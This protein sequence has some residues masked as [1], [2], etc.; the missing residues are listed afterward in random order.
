MEIQELKAYLE[1]M[2]SIY[3]AAKG[4]KEQLDQ[5]IADKKNKKKKAEEDKDYYLEMLVLL[6]ES[7]DEARTQSVALMEEL[8]T[9][10][11]Q[12]VFGENTKFE[13]NMKPKGENSTADFSVITD[14]PIGIV[15]ADPRKDG[16]GSGD[17]CA[18]NILASLN[19]STGNDITAP[20][21]LDEPTKYV[22]DNHTLPAA[23]FIKDL[24]ESFDKQ[25]IMSTHDPDVAA[26]ADKVYYFKK[27]NG[28]TQITEMVDDFIVP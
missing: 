11:L 17:I 20:L 6:Q 14:E 2:K 9:L 22:D 7:S 26:I 28:V 5:L 12:S 10:P 25:I 18:L 4:K 8:V 1:E 27:V 13:I 23:R 24:T 19:L 21:W 16:G 3:H 15:N